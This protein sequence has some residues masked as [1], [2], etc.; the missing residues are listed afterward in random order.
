MLRVF[1]FRTLTILYQPQDYEFACHVGVQVPEQ[2]CS[3]TA[4]W[5]VL[6]LFLLFLFSDLLNR[7]CRFLFPLG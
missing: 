6:F 5:T 3:L 7:I 2:L 4:R 1:V